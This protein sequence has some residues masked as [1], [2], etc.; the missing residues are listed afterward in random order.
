MPWSLPACPEIF[1]I[2][3]ECFRTHAFKARPRACH[4]YARKH[5]ARCEDTIQP[6]IFH[7]LWQIYLEFGRF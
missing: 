4:N 1:E 6:D 5:P 2:R 3:T 7:L